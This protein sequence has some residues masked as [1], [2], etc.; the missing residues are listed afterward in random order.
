MVAVWWNEA[1]FCNAILD[2]ESKCYI[3]MLQQFFCCWDVDATMYAE[4]RCQRLQLIQAL[5]YDLYGRFSNL[6]GEDLCTLARQAS[7]T[8]RCVC[9][10]LA[11]RWSENWRGFSPTAN[12]SYWLVLLNDGAVTIVKRTFTSIKKI[13]KAKAKSSSTWVTRWVTKRGGDH[14]PVERSKL[15]QCILWS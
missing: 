5:C 12:T 10:T 15:V 8:A 14:Y 11:T 9:T 13:M 3:A 4:S 7:G 2:V 6:N 1:S